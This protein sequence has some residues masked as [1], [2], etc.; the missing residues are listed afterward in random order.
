MGPTFMAMATDP[1]NTVPTQV[2]C[3]PNPEIILFLAEVS[4]ER[5]SALS[6]SRNTHIVFKYSTRVRLYTTS[7]LFTNHKKRLLSYSTTLGLTQLAMSQQLKLGLNNV[8]L[9]CLKGQ[10]CST[11]PPDPPLLLPIEDRLQLLTKDPLRWEEGF[12]ESVELDD[13]VS[14]SELASPE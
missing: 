14:S 8:V 2:G 9:S 13:C 1:D 7:L 12:S 11:T 4:N 3:I 5:V 6:R 10:S